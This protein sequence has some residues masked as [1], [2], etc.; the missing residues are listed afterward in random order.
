MHPIPKTNVIR[1]SL[2]CAE[3]ASEGLDDQRDHDCEH[4]DQEGDLPDQPDACLAGESELRITPGADSATESAVPVLGILVGPATIPPSGKFV[5]TVLHMA[6]QHRVS[7]ALGTVGDP[8][9][10]PSLSGAWGAAQA[11]RVTGIEPA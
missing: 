7:H 6:A 2:R 5:V 9:P 8:C 11:E 10:A 1:R 3:G 4:A